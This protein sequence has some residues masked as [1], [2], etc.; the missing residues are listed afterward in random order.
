MLQAR[1]IVRVRSQMEEVLSRHTGQSLERVRADTDRDMVLP[2]EEAVAYGL[3]DEVFTA[4][5]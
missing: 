1:E 3:V 4:R 5:G 2:A